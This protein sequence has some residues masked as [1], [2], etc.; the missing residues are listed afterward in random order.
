AISVLERDARAA[1]G[2]LGLDDRLAREARH[3]VERLLH[4]DAVDDVAVL[5][6]ATDLSDDRHRERVPLS[7]ELA[8][9]DAL[10]VLDLEACTVLQAVALTLTPNLVD[11]NELT[12]AVHYHR[13]VLLL[14]QLDAVEADR[15]VVAR[16]ERGL[17]GANL[18]DTTDVE[19]THRELRARLTD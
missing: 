18:T 12:L 1:I 17:L 19:R 6:V 2:V 3:F 11:E 13:V 7:H 4:R 14:H 16:F 8:A 15:A 10:A 9:L 5:H